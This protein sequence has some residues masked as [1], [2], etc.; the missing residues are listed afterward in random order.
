MWYNGGVTDGNQQAAARGKT[1][2]K[3]TAALALDNISLNYRVELSPVES[4]EFL[5]RSN[6]YISREQA[7]NLLAEI[8]AYI[9]RTSFGASKDRQFY[10]LSIGRECSRVIYVEFAKA[11]LPKGFDCEKLTRDIGRAAEMAGAD[12]A[13]VERDDDSGYRFRM[14]WD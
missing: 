11:Y 13:W 6:T 1:M 12:E 14:W 4:I 2:D 3:L 9:P 7:S 5:F 10:W 8:D